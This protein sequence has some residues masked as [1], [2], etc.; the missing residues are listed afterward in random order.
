[1][2]GIHVRNA[3]RVE[4]DKRPKCTATTLDGFPCEKV[5]LKND[6]MCQLHAKMRDGIPVGN[7]NPRCTGM[8]KG[9]PCTRFGI[10]GSDPPVCVAHSDP[11]PAVRARIRAEIN[12]KRMTNNDRL[13][14][15]I[16]GRLRVEELT[17][18]E[19]VLG[20]PLPSSGRR[21]GLPPT[22]IPLAIHKRCTQEWFKR[23]DNKLK[24]SLV[25]AVE[26]MQKMMHSD[27]STPGERIKAATWI[28]ERV[29][30][31]IPDV[32]QHVQE[33]PF[34]VVFTKVEATRRVR[35]ERT[36]GTLA[37]EPSYVDAEEV[38]EE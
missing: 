35:S 2:C 25:D 28:Y 18:E 1:M 36:S 37:L 15:L 26:V 4:N 14:D 9:K 31:K 19:L 38:G 6:P 30:G 12:A 34:E 17:D 10:K 23:A 5:T 3:P 24:E 11:D 32:V 22:N 29:R 20:Y 7:P 13:I 16:A 27:L 33:R 21:E 8:R